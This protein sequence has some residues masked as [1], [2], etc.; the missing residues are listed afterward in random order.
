MINL[1][2]ETALELFEVG[3]HGSLCSP[4]PVVVTGIVILASGVPWRERGTHNA[5][6]PH[7]G[8]V[9]HVNKPINAGST[10]LVLQPG[11][12]QEAVHM[13]HQ[14]FTPGVLRNGLGTEGSSGAGV[15]KSH[16]VRK[17]RRL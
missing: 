8:Q 16:S 6:R 13:L 15:V 1:G 3:T 9:I 4:Y 5:G 17:N 2:L 10:D 11:S 14:G 12:G 7:G